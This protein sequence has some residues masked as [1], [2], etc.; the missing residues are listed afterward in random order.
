MMTTTGY[1]SV[2]FIG[3]PAFGLMILVFAM[4]FGGSA[5]STSGAIKVVRHLLLGKV[6]RRELRQALHPEA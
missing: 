2:D 6:L 1:A 4:L 3:W 5:G